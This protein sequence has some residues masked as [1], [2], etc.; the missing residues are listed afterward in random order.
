MRAGCG[1]HE[2]NAPA[3]DGLAAQRG[4]ECARSARIEPRDRLMLAG[5]V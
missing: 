5:F 1:A 4:Y 2:G 3:P